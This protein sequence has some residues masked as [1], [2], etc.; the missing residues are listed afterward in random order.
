MV[1]PVPKVVVVLAIAEWG[2]DV[3]RGREVLPPEA[4]GA[5]TTS[6]KD[7]GQVMPPES[8]KRAQAQAAKPEVEQTPPR[9]PF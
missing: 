6:D 3:I 2:S 9:L 8:D 5:A 1:P 7:V 4:A